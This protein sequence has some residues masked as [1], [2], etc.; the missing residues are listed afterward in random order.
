MKKLFENYYIEGFS[1][2]KSQ[3][4]DFK[5]F[6]LTARK[7]R[8]NY[9]R[10][11]SRIPKDASIL[12]FGS[13]LGQFL[14]YLQ[15]QNFH[16]I[17][18]ID[19][20]KSQ[21]E[22]ALKMQPHLDI[23]HVEDPVAF[24]QQRPEMYD[25]ITLNDVLEH[26]ELQQIIPLLTTIHFSLKPNGLVLIKTVNGAYPLG[27][28]LRYIDF[29]HITAFHEKSLSQLLRHTGFTDIRCYQEEIGIYNHLFAL[30]K[31]VVIIVRMLL[32]LL[33][34]FSESDWPGIISVNVIATG[35]K[36][37]NAYSDRG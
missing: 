2:S 28:A 25:V 1:Q 3:R 8:W 24:L 36:K 37:I 10:F 20:S 29:T 26:I 22:L 17:G 4:L 14:F 35:K 33:T 23:Q 32:K 11:F 19:I 30:K 7:F 15:K 18:G 12:D 5:S 6:E 9:Q 31:L 21:V 27:S 13:G 34:Y 16:N